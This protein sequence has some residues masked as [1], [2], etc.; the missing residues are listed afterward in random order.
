MD[1]YNYSFCKKN[2]IKVGV[3][4]QVG[5]EM[6]FGNVLYVCN[7]LPKVNS[8]PHGTCDSRLSGYFPADS[9]QLFDFNSKLDLHAKYGNQ[10]GTETATSA[11]GSITMDLVIFI[12][13]T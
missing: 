13:L 8:F 1:C 12:I 2:Q 9:T 11:G 10:T 7:D 3:S 5:T 4:G 6:C